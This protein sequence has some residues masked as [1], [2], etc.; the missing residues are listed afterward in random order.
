M[1]IPDFISYLTTEK[2]YSSHTVRAYS[3]DLLAF[4]RF[5]EGFNGISIHSAQSIHIKSWLGAL[6]TE[7]KLAGVSMRRKIASL[8]SWYKF[9][10]RS[11]PELKDPTAKILPPKKSKKLPEAV[12]QGKLEFLFSNIE[13]PSDFPGQRDRIVMIL[14]Y[15][16]GLRRAEL[17]GLKTSDFS[18]ASGTVIIL[19][20]RN[21]QRLIPFGENLKT[22]IESY[23]KLR[24]D[25]A[26]KEVSNILILTNS[27]AKPYPKLIH[28]IVHHYLS[29][30]TTQ[31]KRSPHVLRHSFATHLSDAGADLNAIKELL[32]HSNL[33][34]T[35]I[36]L[37]NSVQR[38]K[39]VY[40]KA[41]PKGG[42]DE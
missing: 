21:K 25:V 19:G 14:L 32:G 33:S 9:L 38:L 5:L 4:Q 2:R 39:D 41:H 22:E 28:N 16:L 26:S 30:V 29:Q 23:I 34:A 31:E 18:F 10:K 40:K 42:S 37:H 11:N 3:D 24:A 20:K 15:A 1:S 36:Y 7:E 17:L 12:P 35:Q 13:F 27:G 6:V 8:R